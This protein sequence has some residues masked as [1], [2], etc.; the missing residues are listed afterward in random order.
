MPATVLDIVDTAVK[1][2]LGALITSVGSHLLSKQNHNRE[3]KKEKIKKERELLEKVAEEFEAFSYSVFSFWA[4]HSY[5]NSSKIRGAK[6][7][8]EK[9][10]LLEEAKR[11]YFVKSQQLT[12]AEAKLLL[13]GQ[14][15]AQ[16]KLR[17]FA[18]LLQVYRKQVY[19][20]STAYEPDELKDWRL[21]IL[22]ARKNFYD[23]MANAFNKL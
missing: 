19:E 17:E 20:R 21:K 16:I 22:A 5:W 15:E 14:S 18:D 1:I 10:Q 4:L 3:T 2:G 9:Q 7:S 11:D 8:D 6:L 23:A 13:L 12:S